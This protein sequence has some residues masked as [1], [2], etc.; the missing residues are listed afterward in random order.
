MGH[1]R[2]EKYASDFNPTGVV[3][4][5]DDEPLRNAGMQE[6]LH[7]PLPAFLLSLEDRIDMPGHGHFRFCTLAMLVVVLLLVPRPGRADDARQARALFE[8]GEVQY[9]LGK[10]KLA[11]GHYQAALKLV[12]RPSIVYNIAQCYLQLGEHKK[13]LFN[14]KLFLS[15]YAR[16]NPGAPQ[17]PNH[18]EVQK[19][20]K[21]LTARVRLQQDAALAREAAARARAAEALA[22]EAAARAQEAEKQQLEKQR[23]E[24]LKKLREAEE[25]RLARLE[26]AILRLKKS[27]VPRRR[28]PPK[29]GR[30]RVVGVTVASARVL[31]DGTPRAVVPI[32]EPIEVSAG[33]RRVEVKAQ[34][35]GTWSSR[36]HV[37]SK[38]TVNVVVTLQ[39]AE[40]P[41][42]KKFWLVISITTLALAAGA[43]AMAI[44]YAGKANEHFQ[45][46]QPYDNDR[47]L[48]LVGHSVAG[49]MGA[50]SVASFIAYLLSGTPKEQPAA[51]ATVVPLPGGGAAAT[52]V[53]RF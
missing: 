41:G 32:K 52:G 22:R 43:E 39:P 49:V 50:A 14:Y 11:L 25:R 1:F 34:G 18:A 30:I 45:G 17:P 46:T 29:P 20:V 9:R 6:S 23:I 31:V 3:A 21:E 38:R 53:F 26:A 48:C 42:H 28:P 13:A 19:L 12:R 40:T 24:E 5:T 37:P 10:F 44:V 15:D 8:K 27:T 2:D 36:V 16:I 51:T 47:T 4:E 7:S 35:F 33:W